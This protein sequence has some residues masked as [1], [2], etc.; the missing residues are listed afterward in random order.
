MPDKEDEKTSNNGE[1]QRLYPLIHQNC[2][3]SVL[4]QN[5]ESVEAFVLTFPN[6]YV[7]SVAVGCFR[8]SLKNNQPQNED[9]NDEILTR[10]IFCKDRGRDESLVQQGLVTLG[11]IFGNVVAR[12]QT[13]KRPKLEE[14]EPRCAGAKMWRLKEEQW[15]RRTTRNEQI[16][17]SSSSSSSSSCSCSSRSSS[18]SSSSSVVSAPSTK[19]YWLLEEGV[20]YY[21]PRNEIVSDRGS[22]DA[23]LQRKLRIAADRSISKSIDVVTLFMLTE[24]SQ[25][26]VQGRRPEWPDYQP[27]HQLPPDKV[28]LLALTAE[29]T[30]LLLREKLVGFDVQ[31]AMLFT[32]VAGLPDNHCGNMAVQEVIDDD[33]WRLRIVHFD[34]G[35]LS[36]KAGATLESLRLAYWPSK[37]QV[38]YD[39]DFNFSGGCSG[40]AYYYPIL[41]SSIFEEASKAPLD[42][43]V[44]QF[45]LQEGQDFERVLLNS[46]HDGFPAPGIEKVFQCRWDRMRQYLQGHPGCGCQ[47]LAFH[48]IT[49]WGRDYAVNEQHEKAFVHW[50]RDVKEW[51]NQP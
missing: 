19:E 1:G 29:E 25:K 23:S 18:S 5:E 20:V 42:P 43:R 45:L 27:T 36:A 30:C 10:V 12:C 28:H 39:H 9:D 51:S 24:C 44:R 34:C 41:F 7:G 21:D 31:M 46:S 2:L 17:A 26:Y 49:A 37:D 13:I 4:Q 11:Q 3:Q 48:T 38:D 6:E 22:I 33:K 47:D 8:Y 40:K 14:M 15:Q 16:D 50:L 32:I 35:V